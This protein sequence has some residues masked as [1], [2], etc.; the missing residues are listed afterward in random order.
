MKKCRISGQPLTSV[1]NFGRQPLGNGFLNPA[2]FEDEY[3][4]QMSVGFSET[5]K[6]FQ[7]IDQP[8]PEKMFHDHYAFYSSTSNFMAR[9]FKEFASQ[10]I[11]SEYLEKEPF[12][13]ELGCNDGIMLKNFAE[14]NIRHLGIEP[15]KYVALE[16]NKVGVRTISE[17]FDRIAKR[18]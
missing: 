8:E 3:F 11:D 12:V 16:A 6:M 10:V 2:S 18:H 14:L 5:S 17:F 9:H 13:V 7:L 1:A 4:F 15:S